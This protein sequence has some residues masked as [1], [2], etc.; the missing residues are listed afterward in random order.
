[1][2][3]LE[4]KVAFITGVARG[5]GRSHAVAL[6]EQ[7][8][9]IIGVDVCRQLDTV[10]YP[11]ATPDDLAE[12]VA[13]VEK[14]DRRIIAV[15]GDVRDYDQLDA[16]VR[17]G[18]A[19]LGR[20]DIVLANAGVMAHG[21]PPIENSREAWRDSIDIMLTGVWNTLQVTVPHL[22]AGGR[23]GSIVVTSSS[24]GLRA[25]GTDMGGGT[26]GYFASKFG[27]VGLVKAY[28]NALGKHGIRVNSIHPTGVAT[29]MV[30]NEFFPEFIAANP[31][32]GEQAVNA[33][34]VPVIES[35]DVSRA[36]LY[37]VSDHGRYVTGIQMPVDAGLTSR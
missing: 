9:D 29:P 5:Q 28:A 8:V 25:S 10:S 6:A 30:V 19:E 16:A 17:A 20:L 34:P 24:A 33:L 22:I 12:T 1:M 4:G 15:E 2:Y 23:G 31:E 37:L 35:I 27:V 32:L 26:D 7:G 3:G 18:V 36:V 21:V 13:L 11:M 14:L